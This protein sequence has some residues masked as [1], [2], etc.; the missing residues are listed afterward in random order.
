MTVETKTIEIAFGKS[1]EETFIFRNVSFDTGDVFLF[2]ARR[3]VGLHSGAVM[4]WKLLTPEWSE[5]E[6]AYIAT[7]SIPHSKSKLHLPVGQ[8]RYGLALYRQATIFLGLPVSEDVDPVIPSARF[9]VID[10]D[11][12]ETGLS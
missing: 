11:A 1:V 7:L 12:K 6:Q 10:S 3:D 8:H 4:F 9:I 2:V 5:I